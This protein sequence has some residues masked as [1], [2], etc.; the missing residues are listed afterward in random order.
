VKSIL[1]AER[2]VPVLVIDAG[3]KDEE[4]IERGLALVVEALQRG[5]DGDEPDFGSGGLGRLA[6]YDEAKCA[7]MDYRKIWRDYDN[8]ADL[9]AAIAQRFR[10][11]YQVRRG[12]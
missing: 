8:Q 5:G 3:T 11:R 6:A 10:Q 9:V 1:A 7:L 2:L 12:W 4:A